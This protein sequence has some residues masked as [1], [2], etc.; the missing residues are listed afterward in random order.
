MLLAKKSEAELSMQ[1]NKENSVAKEYKAPK[2]GTKI[3]D[4]KNLLPK[5]TLDSK[6]HSQ[7]S[8]VYVWGS[9]KDGRC[10]NNKETSEKLPKKAKVQFNFTDLS[11]GY[12]HSAAVSQE[13]MVMTWGRGVFGQLGH[14]NSEN[15]SIPTPVDKLIKTQ[16]L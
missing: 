3:L 8:E 12:H 6:V 14:G 9:G 4:T 7:S 2:F 15:C 10:G 11:C 5:V 13:G 1:A 16:V